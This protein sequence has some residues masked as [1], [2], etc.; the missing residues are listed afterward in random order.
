LDSPSKMK[1]HSLPTNIN[2]PFKAALVALALGASVTLSSAGV[3]LEDNFDDGIDGWYKGGTS[4]TLSS[5]NGALSWNPEAEGQ[6]AVIAKQ[7]DLTTL[8]VGETLRLTLEWTPQSNDSVVTRFG[9][10]NLSNTITGDGWNASLP[11]GIGGTA[12]GYFTFFRDNVT[13]GNAARYKSGTVPVGSNLQEGVTLGENATQFNFLADTTYTVVYDITL[14]SATEVETLL[15]VSS[16]DIIHLSVAGTTNGAVGADVVTSFN[17]VAIRLQAGT[18]SLIDNVKVEVVP[19]PAPAALLAAL[20]C[21]T[22]VFRR[23]RSLV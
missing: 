21:F 15:T 8:Q 13:T 10:L 7:F 3:I 4:G 2:N 23:R 1:T 5:V 12:E 11:N 6:T 9:L 19:E 18:T 22:M 20:G 17:T 14:V 16:G